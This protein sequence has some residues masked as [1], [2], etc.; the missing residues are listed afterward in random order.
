MEAN[1]FDPRGGQDLL[2]GVPERVRVVHRSHLWGWEQ[3]RAVRMFLTTQDW[4]LR[5]ESVLYLF[6]FVLFYYPSIW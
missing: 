2:V 3:I 5:R 1:M 6:Y 4:L